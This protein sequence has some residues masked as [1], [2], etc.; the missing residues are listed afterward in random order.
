MLKSEGSAS[1]RITNEDEREVHQFI[2]KFDHVRDIFIARGIGAGMPGD[3]LNSNN[4]DYIMRRVRAL[5]LGNSTVT[6]RYGGE[7]YVG[8]SL[9]GLGNRINPS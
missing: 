4:R 9:C 7:V 3:V 1:S 8:P 2:Q 5:Y 6:N